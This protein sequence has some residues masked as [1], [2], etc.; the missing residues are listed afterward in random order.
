M[1]NTN[2][3]SKDYPYGIFMMAVFAF[4]CIALA[5][6]VLIFVFEERKK[7]SDL[8]LKPLFIIPST[9]FLETFKNL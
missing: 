1:I 2:F 6:A 4:V 5:A 9:K 3:T 8:E 7:I